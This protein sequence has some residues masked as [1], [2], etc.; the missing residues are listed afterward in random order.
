MERVSIEKDNKLKELKERYGVIE[1]IP[2]REIEEPRARFSRAEV[3]EVSLPELLLR[4]EKI[5]G[6]LDVLTEFKK[7]ID[8]RVGG[9]S[10]SI[11]EIRS[12]LLEK[13]KIL[14][15]MEKDVQTVLETVSEVEPE[16]VRKLFS[17]RD[18][19]IEEIRANIEKLDTMVKEIQNQLK[20]FFE[21]ME[22]IK[23]IE[24]IILASEKI[25]K[26]IEKIDEAKIYI[27]KT[28]SKVES[29]FTE[30]SEKAG[31]IEKQK[32]DI[33]KIKDLSMEIVRTLDELSLKLTK[34][35]RKEELDELRN[36]VE[37]RLGEKIKVKKEVKEEKKPEEKK[38]EIKEED[39][40]A[41][42]KEKWKKLASY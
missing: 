8:E 40:W 28:A 31:Q 4:I 37:K 22:K 18:A 26:K 24:G 11:G 6:K 15:K 34:F 3:R 36:E 5:E 2:E 32:N 10:E 14:S 9:F 19:E 29:I 42:L 38:E 21:A 33:E 25:D 1:E 23:S 7:S 27:T 39:T 13:E 17:K 16:K 35:V 12:A 20:N 41:S 30:L